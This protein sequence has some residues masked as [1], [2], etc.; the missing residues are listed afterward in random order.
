MDAAWDILVIYVGM[1]YI[2][3]KSCLEVVTWEE[4]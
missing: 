1:I 3:R 2:W 4:R